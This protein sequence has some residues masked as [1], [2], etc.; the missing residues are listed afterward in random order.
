MCTLYTRRYKF[1]QRIWHTY[2]N[3]VTWTTNNFKAIKFNQSY[4]V[5]TKQFTI[6]SYYIENVY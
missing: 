2:N 4:G 3:S 1:V 6:K 5:A